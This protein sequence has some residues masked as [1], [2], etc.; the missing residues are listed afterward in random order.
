MFKIKIKKWTIFDI[1]LVLQLTFSIWTHYLKVIIPFGSSYIELLSVVL[2]V[3]LMLL[4][5]YSSGINNCKDIFA[6]YAF[7]ILLFAFTYIF[8]KSLRSYYF[9]S[10]WGI[11]RVF[12]V[13]GGIWSY[14]TFRLVGNGKQL[15]KDLKRVAY[16]YF[17]YRL[18]TL[19]E[20]LQE[21]SWYIQ[22]NQG[23][24][25]NTQYNMGFGYAMITVCAIFIC[26]WLER[27]KESDLII[28]IIS[29]VCAFFWG[30]R[31][32]LVCLIVLLF[33][34]FYIH[35]KDKNDRRKLI[36][37]SC[38]VVMVLLVYMFSDY[39][40]WG[41]NSL[42]GML[43]INSRNLELLLSS[44]ITDSNG[45]ETIYSLVIEKIKNVFPFGLGAYGDRM[46]VMP[47]YAWGYS[48][49][50]IL[51]MTVSFGLLGIVYLVWLV[52]YVKKQLCNISSFTNCLIVLI[53]LSA[54]MLLS[55]SFWFYWVFWAIL[56]VCYNVSHEKKD[57]K[58]LAHKKNSKFRKM[59]RTQMP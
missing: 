6:V 44:A 56:A 7:V 8:N 51:E 13:N 28:A 25:V 31:G 52:I 23:V 9:A 34:A 33:L 49:S 1:T 42:A 38:L 30:S 12:T 43:G 15:F 48:H 45:R 57:N 14:L 19:I 54:K 50:I 26:S 39:I 29:A 16:I 41:I 37:Y 53:A 3:A 24:Y 5:I 59:P 10:N 17:I 32:A 35:E 20:M 58:I 27:K 18:L 36:R 4:S 22:N 2:I 55:D 46:V 21:G 40:I 11:E 47:Y